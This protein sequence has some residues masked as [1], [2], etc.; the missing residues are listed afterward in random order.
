MAQSVGVR[1]KV[2][3]MVET[4]WTLD[5]RRRAFVVAHQPHF[6]TIAVRTALEE[7][8]VHLCALPYLI[9]RHEKPGMLPTS[10]PLDGKTGPWGGGSGAIRDISRIPIERVAHQLFSRGPGVA[11]LRR[12]VAHC[13]E[14]RGHFDRHEEGEGWRSLQRMHHAPRTGS[15][16]RDPIWPT[17]QTADQRSRKR[18]FARAGGVVLFLLFASSIFLL[19]GKEGRRKFCRLMKRWGFC[20]GRRRTAGRHHNLPG[21]RFSFAVCSSPFAVM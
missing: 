17:E 16:D 19:G 2:S 5:D 11:S 21:S 4:V 14:E 7:G 18:S 15:V 1:D 12:I 20:I 9:F 8:L 3:G 13:W 10:S 6:E